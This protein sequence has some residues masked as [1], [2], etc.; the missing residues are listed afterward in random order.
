MISP[1]PLSCRVVV[2]L[3]I[4]II[5]LLQ[6]IYHT[7]LPC[8]QDERIIVLNSYSLITATWP[9]TLLDCGIGC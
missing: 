4:D 1:P 9:D 7:P 3:A 6:V 2:T 8:K 5:Q